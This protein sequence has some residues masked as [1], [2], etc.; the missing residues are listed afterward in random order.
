[1]RFS[2]QRK[3]G[4]ATLA[5]KDKKGAVMVQVGPEKP[6]VHALESA[7]LIFVDGAVGLGVAE[8]MARFNLYQDRLTVSPE[9]E[10]DPDK[11]ITRTICARLVMTLNT[12]QKIHAWLGTA[13]DKMQEESEQ[14]EP[15]KTA[16]GKDATD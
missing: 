10:E 3:T 12:M 15:E 13:I 14:A 4:E 9:Q 11:G 8:G 7:P 1:M 5:D 16:A 6:V 2:P